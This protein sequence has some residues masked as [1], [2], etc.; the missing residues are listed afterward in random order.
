MKYETGATNHI[1]NDIV[2]TV[3]NDGDGSQCGMNYSKRCE[4]A[5]N[6]LFFYRVAC[7]HY[8]PSAC[9]KDIL[10]AADLIQAYYREHTKE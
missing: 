2:L 7:R 8:K 5:E 1:V 4:V 9:N 6:G 3:I 10:E